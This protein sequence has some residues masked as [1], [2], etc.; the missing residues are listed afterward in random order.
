MN[1]WLV[2]ALVA[3]QVML[4]AAMLCALIRLLIGPRAQDRVLAL[5]TMYVDA[6]LLI[7]VFGMRE[8]STF[9]FEAALVIGM[10]GFVS[11]AALAKF[12]LRGEVIE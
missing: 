3:A 6:M 9:Y 4:A 12:L 11:T 5:D 7:L 8:A 10:L 2:V 1:G